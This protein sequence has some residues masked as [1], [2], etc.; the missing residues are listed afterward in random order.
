MI[1][2][3]NV[4]P[5]SDKAILPSSYLWALL[6]SSLRYSIKKN[7]YIASLLPMIIKE[8]QSSLSVCQLSQMKSEIE[9]ELT[10]E[11]EKPGHLGLRCDIQA[12][13][14]FATS[15]EKIIKHRRV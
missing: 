12:W 8:H 14:D 5:I 1:V 10:I 7:S 15:L 2:R 6:L 13:K 4:E 11:E 9:E 3:N